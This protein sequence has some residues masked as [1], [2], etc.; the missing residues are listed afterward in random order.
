MEKKTSS[1]LTIL[2]SIGLAIGGR[3]CYNAPITNNTIKDTRQMTN[4]TQAPQATTT[5]NILTED[6]TISIGDM[7]LIDGDHVCVDTLYTDG[8]MFVADD[9]GDV[10]ET[11]VDNIG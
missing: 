11:H 2:V 3:F 8:T 4:N 10:D 1:K 6:G 5:Y 7:V 9:N